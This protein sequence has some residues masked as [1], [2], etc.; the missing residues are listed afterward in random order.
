MLRLRV[1]NPVTDILIF[2]APAIRGDIFFSLNASNEFS[3]D[4]AANWRGV[5]SLVIGLTAELYWQGNLIFSGII[6]NKKDPDSEVIELDGRS[7]IDNLYDAKDFPL[8]QYED[9][10]LLGILTELLLQIGW[11]LGDISTLPDPDLTITIDLRGERNLATQI[12]KLLEGVPDVFYRE[13]TVILGVKTLD[14]GIFENNS[15]IQALGHPMAVTV[16]SDD[17]F[18]HWVEPDGLVIQ[19]STTEVVYA[20]RSRAGRVRTGGADRVINLGDA[21]S[22]DLTRRFDVSYPIIEDLVESDWVALNLIDFPNPGGRI[23]CPTAALSILTLADFDISGVEQNRWAMIT[24]VPFP[25]LFKEFSTWFGIVDVGLEPFDITWRLQEID[26]ADNITVLADFL[27]TGTALFS[28]IE[29]RIFTFDAGSTFTFEKGKLYGI[30]FGADFNP[31][32]IADSFDLNNGV[33][34]INSSHSFKL[35]YRNAGAGAVGLPWT[36]FERT[37][38]L[39]VVSLPATIFDAGLVTQEAPKYTPPK[40]GSDTT[41]N[42]LK[43][44]GAALWDWTKSFLKE[45]R[46]AVTRYTLKGQGT[47][48]FPKVG[49]TIFVAS[50]AVT[51]FINPFTQRVTET[52]AEVRDNLKVNSVRLSFSGDQIGVDYDLEVF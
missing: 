11:E 46:P 35:Q 44:S 13:G 52:R 27:A 28:D 22:D 31:A 4:I 17:P 15:G 40:T 50:S 38:Y 12:N 29:D 16:E 1:I 9:Q 7:F 5:E 37:P 32:G 19:Q 34:I 49:E 33:N 23:L 45:H 30:A 42:L 47:R 43:K 2:D 51:Q 14:V 39:E 20:L 6:Q 26:P 25:G 10:P 21:L 48:N 3:V 36:N 24:F 41:D 18:V 8:A